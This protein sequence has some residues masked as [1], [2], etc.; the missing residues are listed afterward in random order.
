MSEP[1]APALNRRVSVRYRWDGGALCRLGAPLGYESR[2]ARVENVSVEGIGLRLSGSLPAGVQVS[3]EFAGGCSLQHCLPA[4]V[5]YSTDL[6]DGTWRVGCRFAAPLAEGELRE[7]ICPPAGGTA[8][9]SGSHRPAE[10]RRLPG[11]LVADDEQTIRAFLSYVLHLRGYTAWSVGNGLEAAE[12]L[13]RHGDEIA[14]AFLDMQMPGKSGLDVLALV[15]QIKPG[16][17]CC[18]MTGGAL[19]EHTQVAGACCLLRKPFT[20][21]EVT[22]CLGQLSESR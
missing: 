11:V 10:N 2:W 13:R 8:H 21:A 4:Q 15:K 6:G 17:R 5:V 22:R 9:D 19:N 7:L 12:V 3:V 20:V 18:L 14:G 1:S 16:L